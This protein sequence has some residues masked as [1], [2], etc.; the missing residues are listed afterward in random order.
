MDRTL[1]D[2]LRG[3]RC[4]A[5]HGRRRAK[6][7]SDERSRPASREPRRIQGDLRNSPSA[8]ALPLRGRF[9]SVRTQELPLS[10]ANGEIPRS[11]PKVPR[12]DGGWLS[13]RC[14]WGCVNKSEN[15]GATASAVAV[16][17]NR[18]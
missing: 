17:A 9:V 5:A 6:P 10:R 13:V 8:R 1:R 16:C 15:G 3:G 14:E 7:S 2:G 4:R 18:A 12:P 11:R